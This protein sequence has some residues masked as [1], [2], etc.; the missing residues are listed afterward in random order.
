MNEKE[1]KAL[2]NEL[3]R[4]KSEQNVLAALEIYHPEVELISPSFEAAAVGCE[5]V[6]KQLGLFFLL[7]PDYQVTLEDYAI[8]GLLMLATATVT[9]SVHI[10]GK[11]TPKI[12]IPVFLEFHFSDNRISKEVFHMDAGL[13]CRRSGISEDEFQETINS[14]ITFKNM[15]ESYV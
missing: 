14:Y 2:V 12:T 15:E 5:E 10:P 6:E 4:V 8:N 7:F 1:M 9:L 3:A 11:T 13:I